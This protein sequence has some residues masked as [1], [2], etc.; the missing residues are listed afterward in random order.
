[1]ARHKVPGVRLELS[2]ASRPRPPTDLLLCA[3]RRRCRPSG[4][5]GQP[6][7]SVL[8]PGRRRVRW[9]PMVRR[10]GSTPSQIPGMAAHEL[11]TNASQGTAPFAKE[12]RPARADL[13]RNGDAVSFLAR[14]AMCR[15]KPVYAARLWHRAR[16]NMVGR[17]VQTARSRRG[18][19]S[20]ASRGGSPFRS[21][22][23]TLRHFNGVAESPNPTNNRHSGAPFLIERADS[24]PA[25][26]CRVPPDDIPGGSV[27]MILCLK[28]PFRC[29]LP[30]ES[31]RLRSSRTTPPRRDDTGRS[32]GRDP[33]RAHRQLSP[34]TSSCTAS[35][36][37]RAAAC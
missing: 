22:R 33:L 11:A 26:A 5:A 6:D 15:L 36:N 37:H 32:P 24:G 23:S 21:V 14:K 31:G 17:S 8:A 35:D 30:V 10:R 4:I 25:G 27:P 13:K 29:R 16:E 34:N 28:G 1:M 12:G 20:T 18:V 19:S 2:A 3:R 7:R 9:L